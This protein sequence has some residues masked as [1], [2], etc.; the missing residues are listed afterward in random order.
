MKY[1]RPKQ[2]EVQN[3]GT[4][5]AGKRPNPAVKRTEANRKL[6]EVVKPVASAED[7]TQVY[8]KR[9]GDLV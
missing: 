9:V 4:S 2:S 3:E 5:K 1:E 7:G 8:V 6:A